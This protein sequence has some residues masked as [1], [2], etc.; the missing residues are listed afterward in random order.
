MEG[1]VCFAHSRAGKSKNQMNPKSNDGCEARMCKEWALK[2]SSGRNGLVFRFTVLLSCAV[3]SFVIPLQAELLHGQVSYPS[4]L[5]S[6]GV[7]VAGHYTYLQAKRT[8]LF[9]FTASAFHGYWHIAATNVSNPMDWAEAQYD[10][11]SISVFTTH[12]G[13]LGA[14]SEPKFEVF[15]YVYPG[16]MYLPHVQDSAHIFFPWL[17]FCVS[18]D[19]LTRT[20]RNGMIELPWPW[21]NSR[22]S[23]ACY[24]Y[25]WVI[26]FTRSGRV[27]EKVDVVRDSKLDLESEEAEVRRPTLEYPFSLAARQDLVSML[28]LRKEVPDGFLRCA[29]RC[30]ELYH[31]NGLVI[32]AAAEFNEYYPNVKAGT[33]MTLK[34]LV[35]KVDR[36]ELLTRRDYRPASTPGLTFVMD[37]RYEASNERT[38]YN[39]AKYTL[40]GG[41]TLKPANDPALLAEAKH[42]LTHGPRFGSHKSK[43]AWILVG[44][45]TTTS[46]PLVLLI[47]RLKK[48]KH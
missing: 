33:V 23:L 29:Y 22:Y 44:L 21:G 41:Q 42:W 17:A 39:Y 20:E 24:G 13:Q 16:D 30:T 3:S 26:E 1:V 37:F 5:E 38:K 14:S 4:Y 28:Q 43:R 25:K 10:G 34:T 9:F 40:G 19:A 12:R 46:V 7:R 18:P 35:M 2:V 15:G 32:P 47:I 8:N 36:V 11:S 48:Q 45:A 27:V 31:T 6:A